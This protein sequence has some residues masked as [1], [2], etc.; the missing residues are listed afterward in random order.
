MKPKVCC[1]YGLYCY[2]FIWLQREVVNYFI[3]FYNSLGA[4]D[5]GGNGKHETQGNWNSKA[6]ARET[7]FANE[8]KRRRIG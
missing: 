8:R 3:C 6:N 2:M 1:Y 5:E 4:K 7:R